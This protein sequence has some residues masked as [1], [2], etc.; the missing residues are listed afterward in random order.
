MPLALASVTARSLRNGS[1]IGE[2]LAGV[3][4]VV[5]VAVDEAFLAQRVG[6]DGDAG[7]RPGVDC[8]RRNAPSIRRA[9]L[10]ASLRA[11]G[12][13]GLDQ[14]GQAGGVDAAAFGREADCGA[15]RR[16]VVEVVGQAR[17][18]GGAGRAVQPLNW[19]P[20]TFLMA[21]LSEKLF[22]SGTPVDTTSW[23]DR[24]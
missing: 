11:V 19:P 10:S 13:G 9:C 22:C 5:A 24:C 2:R 12:L 14:A 20:S 7:R 23:S 3:V 16:R 17:G 18:D 4:A 1:P 8:R 21:A 6:Q 15:V